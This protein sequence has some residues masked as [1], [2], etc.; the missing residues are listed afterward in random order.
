LKH[1][2]ESRFVPAGKRA[3]RVG[4]F[5]LR[6]G[7]GFL[8]ALRILIRT[9]IKAVQLVIQNTGKLYVQIVAAWRQGFRQC[10]NR[11]FVLTV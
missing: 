2:L 10:K 3:P 7:E 9:A 11:L 1:R 8:V 6:R 4:G 5:K